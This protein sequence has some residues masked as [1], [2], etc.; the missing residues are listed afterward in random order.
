[1]RQLILSLVFVFTV[2][3]CSAQSSLLYE[4]SKP[5]SSL[6]SYLFGTIHT[7]DEWAFVFNDSVFWAI[8][9]PSSALF[10]M[11][12]SGNEAAKMPNAFRD[13]FS[14][15][16]LVN[17]VKNYASKHLMP[18]MMKEIPAKDMA[19]KITKQIMPMYFEMLQNVSTQPQRLSFVDQLLQNYAYNRKKG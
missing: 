5:G 2:N 16:Q 1:M 19:D 9:Q 6:K 17:K 15:T 13:Y 18:L 4:I 12:L 11:K 8:D 7:Q 10:E 14:D 3:Y